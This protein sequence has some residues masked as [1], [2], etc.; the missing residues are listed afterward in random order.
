MKDSINIELIK[1]T[2]YQIIS[3]KNNK[4]PVGFGDIKNLSKVD[5]S[6]LKISHSSFYED[7]KWSFQTEFPEYN[8]SEVTVNFT[9]LLSDGTYLTDDK[10]TVYLEQVKDF[11]YTMLTNPVSSRPKLTTYR[12][13]MDRGV[14]WLISYMKHAG[15]KKL[16]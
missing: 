7:N 5:K 4:S 15:I 6:R 1:P 10:N 9:I 12:R 14:K 13:S 3:F 16:C 11:Y 8:L 2:T